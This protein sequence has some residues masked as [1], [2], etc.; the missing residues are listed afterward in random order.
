MIESMLEEMAEMR[1]AENEWGVYKY[2]VHSVALIRTLLEISYKHPKSVFLSH[3]YDGKTV[4]ETPTLFDL[5]NITI[6]LYYQKRDREVVQE[7]DDNEVLTDEWFDSDCYV[8][9]DESLSKLRKGHSFA[10]MLLEEILDA[11]KQFRSKVL[12]W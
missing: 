5:D 11:D 1:Y 7:V 10:R 9:K 8:L 6:Y 3:F 4:L 12:K 2:R